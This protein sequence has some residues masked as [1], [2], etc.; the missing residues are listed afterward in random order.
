MESCDEVVVDR[1]LWCWDGID[2]LAGGRA[3]GT[4]IDRHNVLNTVKGETKWVRRFGRG[5]WSVK[6]IPRTVLTSTEDAFQLHAELDAYEGDRRV[7]S[8][9]G[10][11]SIRRDHV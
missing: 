2:W 1:G 3:L 5:E 9:N 4:R 8:A 10:D 11:R 6:A 7:Y